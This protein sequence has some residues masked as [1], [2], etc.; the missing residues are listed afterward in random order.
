MDHSTEQLWGEDDPELYADDESEDENKQMGR[1]DG[2]SNSKDEELT[3]GE[4]TVSARSMA[5][6]PAHTHAHDTPVLVSECLRAKSQVFLPGDAIPDGETLE[7]DPSAY[8]TLNEVV[9]PCQ[10]TTAV[11][12]SSVFAPLVSCFQSASSLCCGLP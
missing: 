6:T 9:L 8:V 2:M 3:A 10:F 7:A 1:D 11:S 5:A 4:S 12:H